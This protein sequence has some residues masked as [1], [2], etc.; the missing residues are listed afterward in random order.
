MST[1][2]KQHLNLAEFSTEYGI[3]KRTIRRLV[4][5]RV[6]PVAKLSSKILLFNRQK[7]EDALEKLSLNQYA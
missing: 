2:Q 3:P 6:I 4:R 1:L 7:V 5:G